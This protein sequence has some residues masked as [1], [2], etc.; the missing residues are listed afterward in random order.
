QAS[1][2]ISALLTIGTA[3][4]PLAG[5]TAGAPYYQI[6]SASGGVPTYT[7]SL[8]SAPSTFPFDL[9]PA[10]GVIS[11]IA[12]LATGNYTFTLMVSDS[13]GPPATASQ[14][15]SILVSAAPGAGLPS[16]NLAPAPPAGTVG[17]AYSHTFTAT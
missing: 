10:T 6:V 11:G 7:W 4:G 8:S 1:V 12:P 2:T 13:S 16:V 5:A 15:F 9:D 3:A 17:V 14:S